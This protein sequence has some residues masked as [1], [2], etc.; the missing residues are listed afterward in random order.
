MLCVWQ[1]ERL[2]GYGSWCFKGFWCFGLNSCSRQTWNSSQMS[3]GTSK[4]NVCDLEASV[5]SLSLEK[6]QTYIVYIHIYIYM[7]RVYMAHIY[8]GVDRLSR[9]PLGGAVPA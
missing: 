2:I 9:D 5:S 8:T 6:K 4:D 1:L 3:K 7:F